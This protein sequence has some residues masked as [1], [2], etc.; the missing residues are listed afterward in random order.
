MLTG[1]QLNSFQAGQLPIQINSLNDRNVLAF[2]F[3]FLRLFV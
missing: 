2:L 1:E 3:F